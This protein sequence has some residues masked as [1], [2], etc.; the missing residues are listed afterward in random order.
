MSERGRSDVEGHPTAAE[1]VEAA[2][3][4]L[5]SRVIPT[6]TDARLRFQTLV[7]AHA[8]EVVARESRRPDAVRDALVAARRALFDGDDP[9][10][11]AAIEAGDFDDPVSAARLRAW[12]MAECEHG[13]AS[14]N[15]AFL[16]SARGG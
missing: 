3:E 8:L 10:L 4:H 6:I 16:A 11:V 13:L 1:L 12:L 15:P 2:R 7:A 5:I 14:W 9:G